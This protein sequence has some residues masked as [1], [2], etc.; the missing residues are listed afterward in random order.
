MEFVSKRRPVP[1]TFIVVHPETKQEAFVRIQERVAR[2]NLETLRKYA[3]LGDEALLVA[4]G[5]P[6]PPPPPPTT[7]PPSRNKPTPNSH[8]QS[9]KKN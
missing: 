6:P 7:P 1:R 5:P 3:H 8:I 9:K 2:K 4:R